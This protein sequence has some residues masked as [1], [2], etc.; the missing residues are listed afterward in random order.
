MIFDV[1]ILSIG[2]VLIFR[3][4]VPNRVVNV[5]LSIIFIASIMQILF[6]GQALMTNRLLKTEQQL[7]NLLA[8]L[9][10]SI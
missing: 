1:L 3:T 6:V 2:F 7:E 5:F 4:L 8:N 9:E 10:D